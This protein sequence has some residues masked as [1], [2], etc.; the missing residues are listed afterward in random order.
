MQSIL[1]RFREPSTW[2][3][4]AA[5]A[6]IFGAPANTVQLVQQVVVGVAGLV[7]IVAPEASAK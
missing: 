4:I 7:A 5:L 1:N 6:T 2:A 3:G